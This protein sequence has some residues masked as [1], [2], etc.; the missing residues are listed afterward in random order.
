MAGFEGL[1]HRA[2]AGDPDPLIEYCEKCCENGPR[3]LSQQDWTALTWYFKKT[4]KGMFRRQRGDR[5]K[6]KHNRAGRESA[7]QLA[8]EVRQ[9]Q[10][11]WCGQN[12]TRT[13]APRQRVPGAVTKTMIRDKTS[14]RDLG[15]E[16]L[17]LVNKYKS[18]L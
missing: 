1:L 13:G 17:R 12:R 6:G 4:L 5:G 11:L 10:K 7:Y 3:Q 8:R 18:R 9:E 15:A 14:D 16:A 2:A